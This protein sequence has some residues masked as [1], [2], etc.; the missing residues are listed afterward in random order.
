[1]PDTGRLGSVA[2][3]LAATTRVLSVEDDPDIA[4]FLR[5]YFRAC[6]YDLV[7]IDPSS[8]HEVIEA[9]EEH[10]PDCVLLDLGLRGF[11]GHEAYRLIRSQDRLSFMP[12]II[13]TADASA[14]ERTRSVAGGVD[15]FVSKPFN[16][17]A[18]ADVVSDRIAAARSLG[19]RGVDEQFGMMSQEYL[20]ARLNDELAV[21]QDGGSTLSFAL[22]QL[23]S[24][25]AMLAAIGDKGTSYVVREL[26]RHA[27]QVLPDTAVLGRTRTDEMAVLL[28][29]TGPAEAHQA[30][31]RTLGAMAGRAQLPGGAEVEVDVA[32]GL[33]A[34][35]HH[36]STP[37]ELY[38]AAD[39]ALAD[40]VDRGH[41]LV[42]AI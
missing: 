1:M 4:D 28:P 38:M 32:G 17:N 16:V 9:V 5:A 18:L 40:A 14:L 39:A 26:V 3:R 8:A 30:L 34:F 36:A 41:S 20:S 23:R 42:T 19:L 10:R 22:I 15:G 35:P 7:H 33:A 25:P 37:D 21:A 2:A 29:N 31:M 24:L 13:V 12:V 6:G 11:S 27:R